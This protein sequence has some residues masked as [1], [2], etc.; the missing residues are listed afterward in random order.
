M[1][2]ITWVL[3]IVM[4]VS[5]FLAG[6]GG[7]NSADVLEDLQKKQ[8]N[9][10]SYHGVGVMTLHG[11]E[12]PQAYEIE[13]CYMAPHFY[14]IELTNKKKD[15]SQIVLRNDDG[16]FVLTPHLKKSFRFQSEWPNN[17]GQAY[18]YQTLV[19][20]VVK[21]DQ[22]KLVE[23]KGKGAY[24]FEVAGNYQNH[25]FAKQKIWL[26]KK[27]YKPMHIQV[28]DNQD[29]LM[30][31]VEFSLFNFDHSFDKDH[32][33][34]ERNLTAQSM[35]S[36][37]T[38]AMVGAG[39]ADSAAVD[40]IEQSLGVIKPAYVPEDVEL[41]SITSA[42][43]GDEDAFILRYGGAYNYTLT[44]TRPQAQSVTSERGEVIDLGFAVGAL[45][46]EGHKTLHW[47][48]DGVEYRLLSADLPKAEMEK[49]A[50][51]VEGQIG[52]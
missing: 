11:G 28:M 13:V 44:E 49:I 14:R 46:G 15:I 47:A 24:V 5:A 36:I 16:V 12:T 25:S 45:L 52:K 35:L 17:Q 32:F 34:M 2:R 48:L 42:K 40:P 1:R 41:L 29:K 30:L 38:S 6:C 7:K 3:A 19:D 4:C 10:K 9:L 39:E 43:V 18:L 20:A 21:D 51:S 23:D 33:S 27:D 22:R 8:S 50:R 26:G 37:P 31:E